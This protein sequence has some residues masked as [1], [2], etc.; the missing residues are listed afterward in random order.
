M[1]FSRTIYWAVFLAGTAAVYWAAPLARPWIRARFAS[2]APVPEE[3]ARPSRGVPV[4]ASMP[5][6][7]TEPEITPPALSGIY[8]AGLSGE[9]V[10]GVTPRTINYYSV[11][12]ANLGTLS[13]GVLVL[14]EGEHK[15]SKGNMMTCRRFKDGQAEGEPFLLARRETLFL[16]GKPSSLTPAQLDALSRYYALE[17]S[18]GQLAQTI[19]QEDAAK[20][21][22]VPAGRAALE[23][24]RKNV[25]EAERLTAERD[26]A[27]GARRLAIADRLHSLKFEETRL[28][29]AL[30]AAQQKIT[31]WKK[32]NPAATRDP[33]ADSRV[34]ELR[35][36]QEPLARLIPGLTN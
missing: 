5:S 24:Y 11:S 25:S 34:R 13:G 20:N 29:T 32:Q 15:S 35:A 3:E 4:P 16:T 30:D 22:F 19:L 18:I 26:K 27:E 12:G 9:A 31:A 7:H 17:D 10:W 6:S 8:P 36:R 23:A 2:G 14:C 28:H 21:P 33:E 1:Q